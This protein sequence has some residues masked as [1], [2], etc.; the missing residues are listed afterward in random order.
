MVDLVLSPLTGTPPNTRLQATCPSRSLR[1][2]SAKRLN[3]RV[4]ARMKA[5]VVER[6]G[7]SGLGAAQAPQPSVGP[8][9]VLVRV[10]VASINPLNKMIR[11][12]EF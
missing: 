3:R 1:S 10:S 11:D 4:R 5:F 2:R 7:K 12:G 9:D 8:H 6:Y